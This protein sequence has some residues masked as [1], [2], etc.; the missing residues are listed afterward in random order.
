MLG[1][2]TAD[3]PPVYVNTSNEAG[4]VQNRGHLLHHPR[5]AEAIKKRCDELGVEA[6]ADVPGLKLAPAPG[7]PANLQQFL[8]K[9]LGVTAR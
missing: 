4:D 7:Q 3:D 9:H 5:H 6:V 1:L 8:F 2:I